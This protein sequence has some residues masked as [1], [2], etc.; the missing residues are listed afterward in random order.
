M[1]G[2]GVEMEREKM[3][4][5]KADAVWTFCS[6]LLRLFKH[7]SIH[8]AAHPTMFHVTN[9]KKMLN[10]SGVPSNFHNIGVNKTVRI[11]E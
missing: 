8:S 1:G 9:L 5:L 7:P 6:P 10:L 4:G 3:L 2:V 11:H